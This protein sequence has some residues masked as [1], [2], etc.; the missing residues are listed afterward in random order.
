MRERCLSNKNEERKR[1][2]ERKG[3]SSSIDQSIRKENENDSKRRYSLIAIP[4]LKI[5]NACI[6]Y[7]YT[8]I[9]MYASAYRCAY[10]KRTCAR[11]RTDSWP[12][13]ISKGLVAI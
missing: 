3:F 1:K 10:L 9:H 8:R 12:L 13:N 11:V 5:S 2:K 7:V 6:T 4:G